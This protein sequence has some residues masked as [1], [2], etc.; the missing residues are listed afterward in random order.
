MKEISKASGWGRVGFA[1]KNLG[2]TYLP[3]SVTGAIQKGADFSPFDLIGNTGKGMTKYKAK[4]AF[5]S[6]Y[7]NKNNAK[8]IADVKRS[9]RLNG[10]SAKDITKAE[11]SAKTSYL[12]RY[13]DGYKQALSTGD[14]SKIQKI[15]NSMEKA[16]VSPIDQRKIYTKALS[17]FYK[18]RGIGK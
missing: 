16:N 18:D 17:E 7:E 4:E 12:K 13:K 3:Y 9:M 2:K 10:F 11:N 14:T 1:A 6:A 8:Q 5:K 15:T